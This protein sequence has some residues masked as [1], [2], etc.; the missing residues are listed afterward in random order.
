MNPGGSVKDR[1]CLR[2][3][4]KAE[5]EGKIRPDSTIVEPTS[6]N[7]GMSLAMVCATKGYRLILTMPETVALERRY[8]LSAFGARLELTPGEGGM[9]GAI[10]RAEELAEKK[11]FF[12]PQQFRN[13]ENPRAHRETTAQEI[14]DQ[15]QGQIDAFVCGVGTGGTIT[16]VGEVLKERLARVLIVAVEPSRSAVLSGGNPGPHRIQGIGAGF[17]PEVLNR[18][19]IDRVIPVQDEE[20][21]LLEQGQYVALQRFHFRALGRNC[22]R[23]GLHLGPHKWR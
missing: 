9:R 7:T 20:A 23:H 11:N 4:E 18:K 21:D 22:F 19:V 16:G 1:I 2:M 17:V 6:G 12:M 14:F 10:Q 13:P 15:C 8:L 5:K 3:V